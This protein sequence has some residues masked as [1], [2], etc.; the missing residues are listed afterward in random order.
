MELPGAV[1]QL[2]TRVFLRSLEVLCDH[3]C[4]YSNVH[5]HYHNHGHTSQEQ[6]SSTTMNNGIIYL[7]NKFKKK[8]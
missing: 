4:N 8:W 6:T 5:N 1:Y 2:T 3:L 7:T